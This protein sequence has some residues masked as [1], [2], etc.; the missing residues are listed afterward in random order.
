MIFAKNALRKVPLTLLACLFALVLFG[1]SVGQSPEQSTPRGRAHEHKGRASTQPPGDVI[2]ID[3]NASINGGAQP[4]PEGQSAPDFSLP[5][6]DG[7]TYTLSGFKGD[8]V[9]LS[10]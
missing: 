3:P 5:G 10:S 7:K 4:V 2:Q 8:P 1:C 9:V 6:I